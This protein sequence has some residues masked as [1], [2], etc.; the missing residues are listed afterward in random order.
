MLTPTVLDSGN[1]WNDMKNKGRVYSPP[2][3]VIRII[4]AG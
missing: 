2:F 1:R 3:I 4:F